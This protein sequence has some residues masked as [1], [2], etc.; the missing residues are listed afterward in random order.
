MSSSWN[1]Y[2]RDNMPRVLHL[3]HNQ[4]LKALSLL[5]EQEH[6][7]S[8]KKKATPVLGR[9]PMTAR[10]LP[11]RYVFEAKAN[12]LAGRDGSACPPLL[13]DDCQK[14]KACEWIA[15]T[16]KRREHCRRRATGAPQYKGMAATSATLPKWV[17]DLYAGEQKMAPPRKMAP[18]KVIPQQTAALADAFVNMIRGDLYD[19]VPELADEL[20]P[21]VISLPNTARYIG[22]YLKRLKA[23]AL[24]E[25]LPP[26]DI[27]A[28]LWEEIRGEFW[29]SVGLPE[30]ID[31]EFQGHKYGL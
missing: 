12:P 1:T 2:V 11:E 3:P 14:H 8:P 27:M 30:L 20:W 16:P 22:G 25:D 26:A 18:R 10:P 31:T 19:Q 15:A 13:R 6:G 5:R 9:A 4:R 7:I 17:L 23:D 21:Q 28:S 29:A 24:E